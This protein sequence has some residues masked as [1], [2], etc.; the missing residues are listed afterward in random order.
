MKTFTKKNQLQFLEI[1]SEN[2]F[3]TAPFFMNFAGNAQELLWKPL[4]LLLEISSEISSGNPIENSS[5]RPFE[6]HLYIF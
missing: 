1:Y 2:L 3:F 5:A 6:T 4:R